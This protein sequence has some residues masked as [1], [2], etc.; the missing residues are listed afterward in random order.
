MEYIFICNGC[1]QQK[2]FFKGC[3]DKLEYNGKIYSDKDT[4]YCRECRND[5]INIIIDKEEHET[6]KTLKEKFPYIF[7]IEK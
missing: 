6:F 4:F 3:Y 7:K 2:D 5:F 1:N